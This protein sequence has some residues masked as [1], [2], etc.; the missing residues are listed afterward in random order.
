MET[1]YIA[2]SVDEQENQ[3]FIASTEPTEAP[4][5]AF[6][7]DYK[8]YFGCD[9]HCTLEIDGNLVICTEDEDNEGTSITNMAE[10]LATRVCYNFGIDPYQLTWIEHYPERGDKRDPLPESWDIATFQ[11][12]QARD[13][14]LR[15][16][17]P[18][19]K[20]IERDAVEALKSNTTEEVNPC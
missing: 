13:G 11:I 19:W 3:V 8:G 18:D 14:V 10:H 1:L 9:C 7:Y 20:R 5:G 4:S 17:K 6:R 12:A 15:C 2:Q 16:L